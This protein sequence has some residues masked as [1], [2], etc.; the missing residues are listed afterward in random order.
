MNIKSKRIILWTFLVYLALNLS[1][2][3]ISYCATFVNSDLI[4]AALE[5]IGYY[6]LSALEFLAPPIVA[7]IAILIYADKGVSKALLS[8][9]AI[10]SGKLFYLFPVYYLEYVYSYDSLEAALIS[11]AVCFGAVLITAL[12]VAVSLCVA[13]FVLQRVLKKSHQDTVECLP[14]L[15]MERSNTDFLAAVNIPLTV[16]VLLRFIAELITELVYTIKFFV[17]YGQDYS[18]GE[19]LTI[20]SNYVLLFL[21][22]VGGYILSVLVKNLATKD[23]KAEKTTDTLH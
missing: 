19:I 18:L 9:L 23:A 12:G 3:L 10:L 17:S 14:A 21:L 13:L 6:S 20:L 4:G 16:F 11:L 15:L 5:Y 2:F 22:L 8:V 1:T 7:T